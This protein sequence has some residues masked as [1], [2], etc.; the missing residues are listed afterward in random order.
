MTNRDDTDQ[1]PQAGPAA[2]VAPGVRRL[3]AP[4]PGPF[5]ATG[6]NTYI[7]GSGRVGVIDPGP[8]IPAHVDALLAA[9]AGE[10]VTHILLTHTHRDHSA[11]DTGG[12]ARDRCADPLR[13]PASPGPARRGRRGQ[14]ARRRQRHRPRPGPSPRR[15][16]RHRRR[17]LAD[18]DDR[19]PRP[20]RQPPR[21][22]AQ[23]AATS[24]S[25]A[26]TSWDGRPP[27]SRRPTA[28]WAT[29]WLRSTS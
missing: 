27:S 18:R 25:P 29:T 12:Q 23:G 15:R 1:R 14:P 3:V 4:N 9:V 24:P 19:H 11:R 5:T 22:R 16:R 2:L 20:H 13:R 10:T 7:V 28:R 6:T 17:R 8:A 26:I 21:L